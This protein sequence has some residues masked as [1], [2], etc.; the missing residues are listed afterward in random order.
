MRACC[1]WEVPR[2]IGAGTAALNVA[3]GTLDL[4]GN[5]L[6]LGQVSQAS[7]SVI[8]NLA[9]NGAYTL[10]VG[11]GNASS[12]L[13]GTIQSTTGSLSLA[14]VGAGSLTMTGNVSLTGSAN[15]TAPSINRRP[16]FRQPEGRTS[17]G[18]CIA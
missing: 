2:R 16:P 4:H 13:A 7:G 11:N 17:T 3:G 10:T 18:A 14:K 12:T 1:S 8:G 5:N 9:G 15:W 6:A